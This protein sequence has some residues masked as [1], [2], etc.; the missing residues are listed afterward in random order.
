M[1]HHSS[2]RRGGLLQPASVVLLHPRDGSTELHNITGEDEAGNVAGPA[3]MT[4]Y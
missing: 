1:Q 3:Y 4:I 2:E